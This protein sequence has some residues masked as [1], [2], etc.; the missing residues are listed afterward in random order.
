MSYHF[1][2]FAAT[3]ILSGLIIAIAVLGHGEVNLP[4]SRTVNP[5]TPCQ[6]LPPACIVTT[7]KEYQVKRLN[8]MLSPDQGKAQLGDVLVRG[9][10]VAE[11]GR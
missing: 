4:R 3:G 6:P 5:T 1:P 2:T 11:G 10:C 8:Y 7:L 9:E